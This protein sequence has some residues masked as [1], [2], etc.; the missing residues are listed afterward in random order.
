[1]ASTISTT[2]V[3]SMVIGDN[4]RIGKALEGMGDG[5]DLANTNVPASSRMYT[6]IHVMFS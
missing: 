6:P 2:K 4:G 3:V 1:M 5:Q